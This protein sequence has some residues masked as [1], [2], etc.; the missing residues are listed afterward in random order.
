MS[1]VGYIYKIKDNTNGDVYYGSTAESVSRRIANHRTKFKTGASTC[2]SAIILKNGDW[3][4]FTV[5][6][7]LY[8]EKFELR[9]RE[10]TF[11]D[12][13]ECINKRRARCSPE[14]FKK[15][16]NEYRKK[17][18]ESIKERVRK[19]YEENKE[20]INEQR[21]KYYEE[22]KEKIIEMKKLYYDENKEKI[23][24]QKKIYNKKNAESIEKRRRK[25]YEE[26]KEKINEKRKIYR[27]ENKEKIREQKKLS[28][29]KNK[30]K[31]RIARL[32]SQKTI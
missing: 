16:I 12:D 14:Q 11:I 28:Y 24:E 29:E 2:C 21:Q 20:T 3:S 5:E 15:R 30:E 17:N 27:E 13:N 6:K 4:Y 31:R 26:N 9:N 32:N 22:N 19:H 1:K 23:M 10:Q 25:Y 18:A 7:F 8:N